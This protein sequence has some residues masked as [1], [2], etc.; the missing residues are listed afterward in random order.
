MREGISV[1][2]NTLDHELKNLPH[3]RFSK[4]IHLIKMHEAIIYFSYVDFIAIVYKMKIW[5]ACDVKQT[6]MVE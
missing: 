5:N 2:T 4:Q 1:K 3:L 6:A